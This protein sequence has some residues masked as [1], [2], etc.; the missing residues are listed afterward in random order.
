ME[1]AHSLLPIS[2]ASRPPAVGACDLPCRSRTLKAPPLC[3]PALR[4]ATI[5]SDYNSARKT[6]PGPARG[7]CVKPCGAT[8]GDLEPVDSGSNECTVSGTGLIWGESR[9]FGTSDF[10]RPGKA[11]NVRVETQRPAGVN[12][13][14][15]SD[16]VTVR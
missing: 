13:R 16:V 2:A 14:V 1:T 12:Q 4:M 9:G 15:L 3:S 5:K 7:N 11:P 8:P 10:W 6:Q